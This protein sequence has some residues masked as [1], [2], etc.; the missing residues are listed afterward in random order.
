M[1]AFIDTDVVPSPLPPCPHVVGSKDRKNWLF[2]ARGIAI[3]AVR[4]GHSW[5]DV[6]EWLGIPKLALSNWQHPERKRH[7]GILNRVD[8]M[9]PTETH[10]SLM[11][12]YFAICK[13]A[14]RETD[15]E[16]RLAMRITALDL[17]HRASAAPKFIKLV[18]GDDDDE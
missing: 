3:T 1:I 10:D 17:L 9:P 13:A 18:E 15:D 14:D 2:R 6:G 16:T 8:T 12:R 5:A 11:D 7:R 4:A